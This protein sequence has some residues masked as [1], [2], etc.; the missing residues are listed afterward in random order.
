MLALL[1][2]GRIFVGVPV[3]IAETTPMVWRGKSFFCAAERFL[4]AEIGVAGFVGHA[5]PVA[6]GIGGQTAFFLDRVWI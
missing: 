2:A 1:A 5:T 3:F 4:I 6:A